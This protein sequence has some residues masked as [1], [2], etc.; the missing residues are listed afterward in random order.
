MGSDGPQPPRNMLPARTRSSS[1][2]RALPAE[3]ERRPPSS[4][5][6]VCERRRRTRPRASSGGSRGA[7]CRLH[8]HPRVPC[9]QTWRPVEAGSTSPR[10]PM[11][12]AA[13][14][15]ADQDRDW[16]DGC[17]WSPSRQ[18]LAGPCRGAVIAKAASQGAPQRRDGLAGLGAEY[19]RDGARTRPSGGGFCSMQGAHI[20]NTVTDIAGQEI[21]RSPPGWRTTTE[22]STSGR[23][24]RPARIEPSSR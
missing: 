1:R 6:S 10:K 16:T 11:V 15:S 12:A 5:G 14:P 3:L 9:R 22:P 17:W 2:L 23:D 19:D 4:A 13:G 24:H 8:H 20:I 21:P 7:R 18:P